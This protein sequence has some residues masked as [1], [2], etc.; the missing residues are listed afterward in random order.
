MVPPS[1]VMVAGKRPSVHFGSPV[2]FSSG[3][4]VTPSEQAKKQQ[5]RIRR[6]VNRPAELPML[7]LPKFLEPWNPLRIIGLLRTR[8]SGARRR[9]PPLRELLEEM[10]NKERARDNLVT[11]EYER[12][13]TVIVVVV[14][15]TL[16]YVAV[17]SAYLY[18]E[19]RERTPATPGDQT[20]PRDLL[21]STVNGPASRVRFF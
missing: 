16:F 19:L 17:T 14:L 10:R 2:V 6:S 8:F 3:A 7:R 13:V 5:Q 15:L 4:G 12:Q 11:R 9:V 20:V 21:R 1:P 18:Y